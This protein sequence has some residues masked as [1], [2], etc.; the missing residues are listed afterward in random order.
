VASFTLT[1]TFNPSLSHVGI[2]TAKEFPEVVS[3][4]IHT[5]EDG[6][7]V[8]VY[9]HIKPRPNDKKDGGLAY[10]HIF[11]FDKDKIAEQWDFGTPVPANP[12]NENGMF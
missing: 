6:D 10:I 2:K 7:L 3:K 11:R 4:R 5:L 12:V 9:S 1:S 8:T